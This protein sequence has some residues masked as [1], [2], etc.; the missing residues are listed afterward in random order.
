MT[1]TRELDIIRLDGLQRANA[2]VGS[3]DFVDVRKAAVEARHQGRVRA[4]PAQYPPAGL[5]RCA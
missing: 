1:R 4:G 3:G 2:G 5:G